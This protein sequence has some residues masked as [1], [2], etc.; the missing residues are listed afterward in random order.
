MTRLPKNWNRASTYEHM[1]P[2]IITMTSADP[3]TMTVLTK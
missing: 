2:R 1:A 3:T